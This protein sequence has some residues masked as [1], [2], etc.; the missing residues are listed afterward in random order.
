LHDAQREPGNSP[1]YTQEERAGLRDGGYLDLASLVLDALRDFAHESGHAFTG[2]DALLIAVREHQLDVDADDLRYVLNVLSRPT[3]L[4]SVD[5]SEGKAALVS[6]KQTNLVERTHYADDYRLTAVGRAAISI[7][8]NIAGF[9]YAEGD[10]L[11]L[12][13]AIEAGDFGVVPAFCEGLM[14]T[15]RYTSVDLRQEI[16]R[17]HVDRESEMFKVKMPRF[18]SVIEKTSE[19]LRQGEA[20]LRAWRASDDEAAEGARTFDIVELEQRVVQVYQA[21]EAFGRDLSDLTKLASQRRASAV[22]PIDFLA[23]ALDLVRHPPTDRQVTA[24]FRQFGPLN[25]VASFASPRDVAGKV[26]VVVD[27]PVPQQH[28][29]TAADDAQ[30]SDAR[31]RFLA[32]YGGVIR[33]RLAT[34][35]LP[36]SEALSSG[37]CVLDGQ[38]ALHELFG[39]Y[40]APWVVQGSSQVEIRVPTGL[41]AMASDPVGN[42]L[43]SNLELVQTKELPQ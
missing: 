6:D 3:E 24:L 11:K 40:V 25:L 41:A 1:V 38:P 29:E 22:E 21:L 7:A 39:V 5:R 33:A 12:L 34:G 28:F 30:S 4:W 2:F 13:R 9:V 14:D 32:Q 15:I 10:A 19:L 43:F 36:L 23:V 27:R 17:G 31:L 26:K 18:R 8:A 20:K 35:P 42:L 16:E 37:W